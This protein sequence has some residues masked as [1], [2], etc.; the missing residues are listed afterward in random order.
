MWAAILGAAT[1]PIVMEKLTM[2]GLNRLLVSKPA[3]VSL[4]AMLATLKVFKVGLP[5]W[6]TNSAVYFKIL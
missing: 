3:F 5:L 4:F 6:R 2:D 1:F